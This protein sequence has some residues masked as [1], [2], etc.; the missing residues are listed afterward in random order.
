MHRWLFACA[1]QQG[2]AEG[3]CASASELC[4][5][6]QLWAPSQRLQ[7]GIRGWKPWLPAGRMFRDFGKMCG[8]LGRR[9]TCPNPFQLDMHDIADLQTRQG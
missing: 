9:R 8:D 2:S 4:N 6:P 5:F 1:E 7:H 3:S